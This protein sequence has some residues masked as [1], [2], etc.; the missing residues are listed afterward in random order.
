MDNCAFGREPF[1]MNP[2]P[3][4]PPASP[5]VK[6]GPG[7]ILPCTVGTWV[8]PPLYRGRGFTTPCKGG[9]AVFSSRGRVRAVS[10]ALV[11]QQVAIGRA[12][13]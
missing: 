11:Q 3:I 2:S 10:S 13:V 1:Q 12:K 4:T 8:Y 6:R 7:Y 9:T 5:L